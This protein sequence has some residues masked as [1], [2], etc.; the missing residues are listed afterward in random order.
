MADLNSCK[1]P[2][3]Y[4]RALLEDRGWSQRLLGIVLDVD[5][6]GVNKMVCDRRPITAE[7]AVILGEVFDVDADEFLRRQKDFDLAKARFKVQPDPARE[8]RARLFGTLP[9]SEMIKRGWIDA[10][11]I[12]DVKAV[13]KELA[14][15]FGVERAEDIEIL[16]HAAKKTHVEADVTPP[17]LAWIYRVKQIADETLVG[18]YSP[19]GV[20]AAVKKLDALLGAPEEAR[21]VPRIL[22]EC[23]IRFVIVETVKSANIDGVCFWLDEKSPVIGM[24][25]RYDRIDN[26]WFVLRHEL[27]HVI[28]LHGQETIALDAELEGKSAGCGPSI[29]E[30]ECVA[31]KAA[32]DFCVP[33]DKLQMFIS[34]KE[35]VF[36]ERDVLAF[37]RMLDVHPGLIVGQIQ[38]HTGR[39]NLHREYLAPVRSIVT[40]DSHVDGWGDVFPVSPQ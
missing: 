17:Q 3:Q 31:N 25:L 36:A 21:K 22:A 38:R 35:P 16:P 4:L 9:V 28:R 10:D 20:R 18:P 15:F 24:T 27:E 32:A 26:F 39:Y 19:V 30:Q 7:T 34:R 12:R 13:E 23:G 6:T 29:P 37:A 8:H 40:R 14:R 5:E 11:D 2:G 1:T 33:Q